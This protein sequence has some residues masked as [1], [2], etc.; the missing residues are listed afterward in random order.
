MVRAVPDAPEM[1][2]TKI[3]KGKSTSKTKIEKSK[4]EKKKICVQASTDIL[5]NCEGQ[6]GPIVGSV[7]HPRSKSNSTE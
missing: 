4:K 2:E 1:D 5:E 3:L 7:P 6:V